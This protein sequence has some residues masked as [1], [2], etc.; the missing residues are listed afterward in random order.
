MKLARFA[1]IGILV[2]TARAEEPPSAPKV[3]VKAARLFDGKKAI[4]H[5]LV[6]G[7]RLQVSTRGLAPTGGYF[8]LGLAWDAVVPSGAQ[9]VDGPDEIRRAVREQVE[10][11]ADWIKA[12]V[13]FGVYLTDQPDRPLRSRPNFTLEEMTA[14]VDEAH[15]HGKRV[16]AHAGG[17][18]AIDLALRTGVDSIEHGHGL[19]EDLA[20]RMAKQGVFLCPTITPLMA[21]A[22]DAPSPHLRAVLDAQKAGFRRALARGVK[23]AN[24]SDAGSYP[25]TNNP[26]SEVAYLVEWGMTPVQALR[27]ATSVAGELFDRLCAPGEKPC[28]KGD[29]GVIRS[30]AFAD[31]IA[32]DADPLKDVRA[33]EAV[34]FVMKGGVVYKGAE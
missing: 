29:T 25:W 23:I 16:A 7:P 24:G 14:L 26:V 21:W 10:H 13:D 20:A 30:G 9:V 15:R 12:Y 17:W 6:P 1:L 28:P 2:S 31:L 27:A 4:A 11:G 19:T 33:L 32:V 22:K 34:R 18:D 5:K 8:P 3:I